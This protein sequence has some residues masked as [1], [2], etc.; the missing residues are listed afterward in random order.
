MRQAERIRPVQSRRVRN[1]VRV[2]ISRVAIQL[3]DKHWE[4]ALPHSQC[5]AKEEERAW[6]Y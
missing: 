3:G 5:E 4:S 6:L 1:R 2:E